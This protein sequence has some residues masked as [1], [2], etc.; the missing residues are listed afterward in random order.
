M[1][2]NRCIHS[3]KASEKFSVENSIIRV[4]HPPYSHGLVPSDFWLFGHM[5]GQQVPGPEDLFTGIQ[6]FLSEIQRSELE[7]VFYHSSE[8]VHWVLDKD[9]NHFHD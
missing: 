5:A 3:S 9:R 7:L 2:D 8:R 4:T 6:E 1:F